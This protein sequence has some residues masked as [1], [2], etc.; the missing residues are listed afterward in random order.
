MIVEKNISS[1]IETQFPEVYRE[2][3][4]FF[5]LFVQKYYEWMEQEGNIL[6][7]AR[8]LP[9]YRDVDLTVD[10]FVVDM[11]EE[12]LNGIQLDTA[13]RTRQLIKHSLD[14]YRSKGS[15]Q[16]VDLF[17]RAIYG[18][19]ASVYYPGADI[20]KPSDG[21]WAQPQYL[22]VT[23]SDQ[24]QSFIGKQ[25]Q[26]VTSKATAFVE[27]YIRKKVNGK[28]VNLLYISAI[29][30]N[31]QTN[32]LLTI[33]GQQLKNIP[34]IIGSMTDIEI[35]EGGSNFQIGDLLEVISVN[36][37]RGEAIVSAT[38]NISSA[39]SFTITDGGWGYTS[40]SE[41]IISD[42][43]L[44]LSNVVTSDN[45][46]FSSFANFYQPLANLSLVSANATLN[47]QFGDTL[48]TYYAN[49]ALS[50]SGIVLGV[51]NNGTNA[52]VLVN[53]TYGNLNFIESLNA[54]LSGTVA[55]SSSDVAL[56][57]VS[58]TNGTTTV[59]GTNTAFSTYLNA[60]DE[61]KLIYFDANNVLLGIEANFVA[62]VTS[63]NSM[64]MVS[65]PSYTSNNVIIQSLASKKLI[66]NGTTFT[67]LSYGDRVAL[68][69]NATST[70]NYTILSVVNNTVLYTQ[71]VIG[72]SNAATV[73]SSLSLNKKIYLNSNVVSA[74]IGVYQNE[75]VTSTYMGNKSSSNLYFSNTFVT[76]NGGDIVTQKNG[77]NIITGSA[78]VVTSLP[79]NTG[80]VV[81]AVS[82]LTG[83]FSN[84]Q[85]TY[86]DGVVQNGIVY[87]SIDLSVG[88][89]DTNNSFSFA[90]GNMFFSGNTT[91]TITRVSTGALAGFGISNNLTYPENVTVYSD[92]TGPYFNIPLNSTQY[93]FPK[94]AFANVTTLLYD[95]LQTSVEIY[96]G[97]GQLVN[98]NPGKNYDNAPLVMVRSDLITDQITDTEYFNIT[99]NSLFFSIGEIITQTNGAE[100]LVAT[101]NSSVLGVKKITFENNFLIGQ[102]IMGL[103]SGATATLN[104][105]DVIPATNVLGNNAIITANV[106]SAVGAISAVAVSDSG[107]GYLAGENVTMKKI[108][109]EIIAAGHTILAKQGGA[110]GFYLNHDGFLDDKNKLYDG[111]YY[112][113]YSYVIQTALSFD[114]YA[115]MLKNII[116]V[117]GTQA[118]FEVA[119][120]TFIDETNTNIHTEIT[121]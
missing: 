56:A 97:I 70:N 26:G 98:I 38:S 47:I 5:V 11:K 71:E 24:T 75:Y 19:P 63:A 60:G 120:E 67:S 102:P 58:A 116:H 12:Y 57:G 114:K 35:L 118:F 25:V 101:S 92:R 91:G 7:H 53:E 121:L 37:I 48:K 110:Q 39:V 36:G 78:T 2:N 27:R 52:S 84:T 86:L 55:T 49:N 45:T 95:V 22:E 119:F 4:E 72:F 66:G 42:H 77:N 85:S 103:H 8:R 13:E 54:N 93:G 111:Y 82:N 1:F 74:N 50:G 109:S 32:E 61:V 20:L 16:S 117:A 96:G 106:S 33:Q 6:Y 14:L 65:I 51:N 34:T 90:N 107:Y 104:S 108:G 59:A 10:Q 28:Y 68:Y 73:M 41:I 81:L 88:V 29:N 69:T 3:G 15:E 30:G 46:Y 79:D 113:D 18:K 31:F 64:N 44:G 99:L 87:K 100:A 112:Q 89:F 94:D 40:N 83:V 9:E 43:I 23:P 80:G 21:K 17:F 115:D 76:Y 62:N 105:I